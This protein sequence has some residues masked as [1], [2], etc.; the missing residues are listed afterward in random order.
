MSDECCHDERVESVLSAQQRRILRALLNES[1]R[2]ADPILREG[3]CLDGEEYRTVCYE[4]HCVLLSELANEE[5]I[6]FDRDEDE[7]RRGAR[8]NAVDR[9]LEQIDGDFDG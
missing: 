4:L 8:F 9:P 2:S 6:E 3:E 7:I 1:S 5:L